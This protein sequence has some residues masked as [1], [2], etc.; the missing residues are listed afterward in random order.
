M[1]ES[2]AEGLPRGTAETIERPRAATGMGTRCAMTSK[3][4]SR[5]QPT[6]WNLYERA[7]FLCARPSDTVDIALGLSEGW[8]D[9]AVRKSQKAGCRRDMVLAGGVE[10]LRR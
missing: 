2:I 3:A 1:S 5:I 9:M 7:A 8:W 10:A 6:L 4:C